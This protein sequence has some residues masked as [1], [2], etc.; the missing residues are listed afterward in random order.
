[1]KTDKSSWPIKKYQEYSAQPLAE[2]IPVRQ[3]QSVRD[4]ISMYRKLVAIT[5]VANTVLASLGFI[6]L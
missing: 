3:L 4:Q 6:Y 5:I 1:M 2:G